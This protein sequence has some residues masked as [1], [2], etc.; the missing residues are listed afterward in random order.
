[1]EKKVLVMTFV[2]NKEKDFSLRLDN[3]AE[4]LTQDQINPVMSAIVSSNVFPQ[5]GSLVA[6]KKAE[7][8]VTT[9][10]LLYEAQ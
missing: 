6:P 9:N 2:D 5:E 1:M 10:Q 4:G 3:P 8:V 7:L